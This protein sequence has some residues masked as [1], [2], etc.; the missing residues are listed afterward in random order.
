MISNPIY[1][2]FT[3]T[4]RLISRISVLQLYFGILLLLLFLIQGTAWSN[5]ICPCGLPQYGAPGTYCPTHG[6][7]PCQNSNYSPG[8]CGCSYLECNCTPTCGYPQCWISGT[9]KICSMSGCHDDDCNCPNFCANNIPPCTNQTVCC[10]YGCKGNFCSCIYM[11]CYTGHTQCGPATK[12]CR[13]IGGC[14]GSNCANSCKF[15]ICAIVTPAPAC[16]FVNQVPIGLC[17]CTC[18][19]SIVNCSPYCPKPINS[20]ERANCPGTCS[21]GCTGLCTYPADCPNTCSDCK[22]K[23]PPHACNYPCTSYCCSAT[24]C[25]G[26]PNGVQCFVNGCGESFNYI[27][28]YNG[29]DVCYNCNYV[30]PSTNVYY[31]CWQPYSLPCTIGLP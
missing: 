30:Y 28:G 10:K 29:I 26:G 2:E 1:K 19:C 5:C 22:T 11:D 13:Q 6:Q 16:P 31:G 21:V 18:G 4:R 20:C 27:P 9:Y 17:G 8:K 24:A 23:Y 25:N 7:G 12:S 3:P 14:I 15:A